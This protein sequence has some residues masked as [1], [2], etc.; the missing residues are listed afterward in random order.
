MAALKDL[1]YGVTLMSI[2]GD[3]EM[4]VKTV[5][6]D[7][8]KVEEDTLFIAIKGLHSDGHDYI[9][10]AIGLGATAILCERLPEHIVPNITYIEAENSM[11]ALG[12]VASNFFNNANN[13]IAVIGITG[14]NGKTTTATLLYQLYTQLGYKTGLISTVEIIIG[15]DVFPAQYT[16][17]D[18]LSLQQ[19]LS[20]MEKSGCTHCFMEVSSHALVQHRTSGLSFKG[21][22]F[23]NISHDHLDYHD[24]FD[25]YIKAKKLLFDGLNPEAFAL[26]NIDD[27]R[28]RVVLQNTKAEKVTYAVKTMAD[29]K[30]KT[31]HN[32]IE[33]L[34]LEIDGINAWFK[35]VGDFNVYNL[36]A[37]Y[38]C[39][40]LLG[41]EK[42]EILTA[43]SQLDGARGRFEII[44]NPMQVLA[45]VDYAHTPDALDNVLSTIDKLRTQ[46]ETLVTV[47]GCGGDRDKTKRPEMANIAA[48]YSNKVI[49]TSD[50]PRTEDP[51]EILKDMMAGVSTI[52]QRKTMVIADRKEAIR[53]ACNL[54]NKGDI[55]LVAGK[56]HET[57]QEI[58]G[59]RHHFDDKE[60]LSE[61]LTINQR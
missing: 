27:K 20:Q 47:V 24:T 22:V 44:S 54:V 58:N 37:V 1:L 31:I 51:N 29:F 18:A 49:L 14:T 6:F 26:T 53:T 8:R 46:Q 30:A 9:S 50:N 17:P 42:E 28:G 21:A 33:G 25:E 12:K 36:L 7:S 32:T 3:R 4:D 15:S 59:I 45:I 55:V 60:I 5:A 13:E 23:T 41:Q 61:M 38:S 11:R 10:N 57:Y 40:S 34:E 52:H 48:R 35:M 19:L 43:L 16:T 39:A 56:G 2:H